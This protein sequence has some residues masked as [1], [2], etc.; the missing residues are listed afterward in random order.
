MAEQL[1]SHTQAP[2]PKLTKTV[3]GLRG[4][5]MFYLVKLFMFCKMLDKNAV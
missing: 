1:F 2:L 3:S 5:E 4:V